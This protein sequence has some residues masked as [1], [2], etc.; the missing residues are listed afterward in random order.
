M[1]LIVKNLSYT[2]NR[3]MPTET[4]ALFDISLEVDR[5]D[6]LSVVGHTGSGKSTLAQ[7]LNGLI[8][9]QSGDV[10]VDGVAVKAKSRDLR[11]VRREVGLV[12]QYPEQQIFAETVEEEIAFGPFNWGFRG[13]DLHGKVVNALQMIGLD[14]SYLQRSPF[15]LSGGQK[16]RLAIASVLSSDPSYIVLDEPTAGLDA[17]GAMDLIT[18]LQSRAGCGTGVV[19]ITHDLELALRISTR[20]LI[21]ENGRQVSCGTP[22]DTAELLRK[23]HV[24]GL[25]LPDVLKFSFEL[26]ERGLINSIAWDP[27]ELAKIIAGAC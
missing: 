20:I 9:P 6:I 18:I 11:K 27:A 15:T 16:R 21:L 1:S 12:F 14:E 7:H 19:H 24:E 25:M 26:K 10:C 22:R 3:G 23:R 4:A 5:G 13:E 8:I 17:K 2:Y